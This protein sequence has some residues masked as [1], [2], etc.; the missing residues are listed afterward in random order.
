MDKTI[1]NAIKSKF[2]LK[3]SYK[4]KIR[5]IEPHAFGK[6]KNGILKLRAYQIEGYSESKE[7]ESWKLFFVDNILKISELNENFEVRTGYNKSGD[8]QIP[9]I[10][11]KI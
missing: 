8:S 5:I 10:I 2:R 4:D 1:C 6:D 7:P 3:I 11:C 9:K